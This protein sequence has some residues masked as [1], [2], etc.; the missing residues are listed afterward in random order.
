[1][2][3]GNLAWGTSE[4]DL[5]RTLELDGRTVTSVQMKIDPD[6]GRSRGFAFVDLGSEDEAQSAIT[7]LNGTELGGRQIKVCIAKDK[8]SSSGGFGRSPFG[9]QGDD[10][11]RGERGD[12]GGYG[13]RPRGGGGGG[14]GGRRY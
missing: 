2:Y 6:S 12:Y 8:R 11:E 9:S 3:V 14:G 10:R 1:V 13:R 5:R 7:A 4:V